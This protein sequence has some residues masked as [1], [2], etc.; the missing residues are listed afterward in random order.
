MPRY[1][2]MRYRNRKRVDY[3]SGEDE[4]KLYPLRMEARHA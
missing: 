3:R 4:L 1:C 2:L